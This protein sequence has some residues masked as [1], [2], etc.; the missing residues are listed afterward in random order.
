VLPG[1]AT[2]S[3]LHKYQSLTA[4]WGLPRLRRSGPTDRSI[5]YGNNALKRH[6]SAPYKMERIPRRIDRR[7]V[8]LEDRRWMVLAET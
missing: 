1:I 6:T 4:R 7:G 5:T 3:V 8:L 2:H